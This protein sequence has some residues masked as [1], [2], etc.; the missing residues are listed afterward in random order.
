MIT[1]EAPKSIWPGLEHHQADIQPDLRAAR[2]RLGRKE[3]SPVARHTLGR[4]RQTSA[5]PTVAIPAKLHGFRA[6]SA[7]GRR[8]QLPLLRV[9][10]RRSL[11][12]NPFRAHG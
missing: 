10:R 11:A 1:D 5:I 7:T 2:S 9:P 4:C 12:R 8:P 6:M 3:R